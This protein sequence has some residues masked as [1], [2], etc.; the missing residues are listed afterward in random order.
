M[1]RRDLGGS[2]VQAR[3]KVEAVRAVARMAKSGGE[4]VSVRIH[5][6]DNS[7]EDERTYPRSSNPRRSKG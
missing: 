7:I 6:V 3:T 4:P 2:V 1:G 5:R